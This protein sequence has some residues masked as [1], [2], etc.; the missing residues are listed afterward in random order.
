MRLGKAN[1]SKRNT[2]CSTPLLIVGWALCPTNQSAT[3]QNYGINLHLNKRNVG[4]SA[5]LRMDI[6]ELLAISIKNKASDLHL[7]AGLPP[8]IRVDGDLRTIN[9]PAI[10]HQDVIKIHL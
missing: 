2:V 4:Q 1:N 6:T 9:L 8:M 7:S 10:E 5:Q 3:A